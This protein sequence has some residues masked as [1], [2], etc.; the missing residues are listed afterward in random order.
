MICLTGGERTTSALARRLEAH[1]DLLHELRLDLLEQVDERALD[2]AASPARVVTCRPADQGGGFHGSETERLELLRRALARR[3]GYLD[4]EATVPDPARRALHAA[5]GG[6]KLI[7]SWHRFD[8]ADPAQLRRWLEQAPPEAD[9]LKLAV[10]VEDAAD[11]APLLELGRMARR[12]LILVAMGAAGLLSRALYRRFGSP[13]TYVVADGAN[14]VAPGQLALGQARSLRV[15]QELTPLGLAGD[16]VVMRSPGPRV[17]NALFAARQL[18]YLYLPV[19]TTRL[20][21]ALPLL[22]ELGFAGLSVTMPNKRTAARLAQSDL[23]AVNTL[24]R[25]GAGWRGHNTDITALEELLADGAGEPALVLG[26]GGAAEAAA[27]VLAA[28][29]CPT[30]VCARD[31]ARA[32]ALAG[33]LGLAALPWDHRRAQ[34]F[35]V[36]VNATPLGSDGE[37]DPLPAD[38]DLGGR[39]VLDAVIAA[40]PTPLARRARARGARVIEGREWWLL[41]GQ[42][43]MELL[44]GESLPIDEMRRLLGPAAAQAG[45]SLITLR[46]PGSK[47]QTQRALILAALATGDSELQGPLDCDDSRA[48]RRALEL[49]GVTVTEEPGCWRVRGGRLAAPAAPLWC[50]EA[51]TT[52]RFLAPLC[53][54]VDG[55][56]RLDGSPRLRERPLAPLLEALERL[57]VEARC[58]GRPGALPV[59]LRRRGEPS[60]GTWIDVSRS[61]Q[62]L[63]GLLLVAPRLPRGLDLETRGGPVSRPYVE[64][65][66]RAL[67]AFGA[68]V[69][70][71]AGGLRVRPSTLAPRELQI[72]GD[73]SAGAFLLAGA[74]L[75]GKRIAVENLDPDSA[76]GDRVIAR[77]LRELA[78]PAPHRF[79]LTD[80]PDLIAPLAAA[81]AAAAHPVEICGVAHAR[82]KESDRV[83]VLARGLRAAGLL[84]EEQPDGL[85]LRPGGA[86]RPAR[87]DPA[88]DHRMAMAFGLLSLLEPGIEVVDPACVGKSYPGFWRDLERLR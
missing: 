82:L 8:A 88:G 34:P 15:E 68:S 43:Q 38:E 83:A 85:T 16:A 56:L 61:S 25:E 24:V 27:R 59:R 10:A 13:W 12:P 67:R 44:I 22:A 37:G 14:P 50:G 29:G 2:L 70:E 62:F 74:H 86:L 30:T 57:G 31:P 65:T 51:G 69:E 73:W 58:D 81:A 28:Q 55:E 17:Y 6:T 64:L 5:R 48:L 32:R 66:L 47:S 23:G 42:R 75:A 41:Q 46:A 18:P 80:C 45:G 77:Q 76:Q 72:E 20:E 33:P 49:L 84:A 7:L 52:S 53:L 63:S 78:R 87:L 35:R 60:P 26:A 54:L 1:P 19:L 40:A 71:R 79:D 21:Q 4:L 11:L 3:P 39:L 9:L 36:L